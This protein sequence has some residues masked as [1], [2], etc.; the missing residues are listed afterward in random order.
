MPDLPFGLAVTPTGVAATTSPT[1]D[2]TATSAG[3]ETRGLVSPFR[4]GAAD[5]STATGLALLKNNMKQILGTRAGSEYS[6]GELPW[7]TD[8]GSLLHMLRFR[9]IDIVT[10]ELARIYVIEALARWERRILVRA[11][12]ITKEVGPNGNARDKPVLL[13]RVAFDVRSTRGSSLVVQGEEL[14]VAA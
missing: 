13:I 3:I 9:N 2:V 14:T 8:F 11:V 12:K 6:T 10:Q 5:V 4:R 7:R 1:L